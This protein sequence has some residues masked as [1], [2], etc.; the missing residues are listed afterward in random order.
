[1]ERQDSRK[2]GTQSNSKYVVVASLCHKSDTALIP[3]K[4]LVDACSM[5]DNYDL[6]EV[7]KSSAMVEVVKRMVIRLLYGGATSP[8]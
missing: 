1:M 6:V 5:F 4:W 2:F 8:F 7:G 3:I